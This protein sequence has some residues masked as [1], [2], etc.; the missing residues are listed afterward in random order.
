MKRDVFST[1]TLATIHEGIEKLA[2]GM[3]SPTNPITVTGFHRTL[4]ERLYRSFNN[5]TLLKEVGLLYQEEFGMPAIALKH[6]DLARQFAPKDRDIEQL[7][8]GAALAM[9]RQITDEPGHSGLHEA[10]H[11]KPEVS[12]LLRKTT[13]LNVVHETR[14][15][16][17]ETTGELARKQEMARQT[18]A[19]KP[20]IKAPPVDFSKVIK[21]IQTLIHRTDFS[22]A[23]AALEETRKAG[24]SADE[25]QACYAQLG[26]IAYD[27]GRMEEALDAFIVMRDLGPGTVEA[28]FNCGLVYQKIGQLENA[29]SSY[30]E[31]SRLAPDNPKIWC[32]LSTVWFELGNYE[33][34]ERTARVALESKTD[35][36]RAWDNLASALSA[37]GRLQDAAEACQQAIRIQPA[38]HSAW[39]KLGVVNFQLDNLVVA[40]EAMSLTGDNPDYFAYVLYYQSMIE[41]R[42]GELDQALQK[43]AEARAA[44]P[45]ND[46]ESSALR[47]LGSAFMKIGRYV[48]AAD[49]YS[50]IMAKHPDDFSGWLALGTAYHKAEQFERAGEAYR[51]ATQLQPDNPIAW[52]NLGLLASD[53]GNHAE[54]LSCFQREVELSPNDAK[55]WYDLGITYQALGQEQESVDAFERAE[56]IVKA[57]SRRSSDLSAA[58]SIVRRLNLGE[59]VLKTE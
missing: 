14:Q 7:Q 22:G 59:R 48:T 32:N 42:R 54:S 45:A 40:L 38:L 33:E 28:W 6:F 41:A 29:L 47:E 44:D 10:I 2:D 43:L 49:F 26:L 27:H 19:L 11:A 39:F 21:D 20:R 17:G 30:Q 55:A 5:P 37:L 52:H 16:L 58:L 13:K 8:K 50:Q 25:L 24:A 1:K 4:F 15:H 46:L 35:Y 12:A 53:R 57:L 31:A 9:A 3:A 34:A 23:S 36:A 56:G 51:Q 18:A